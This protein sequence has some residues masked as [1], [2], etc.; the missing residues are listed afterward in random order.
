MC[1]LLAIPIYNNYLL[2]ALDTI[3]FFIKK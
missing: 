2:W 3:A 1:V